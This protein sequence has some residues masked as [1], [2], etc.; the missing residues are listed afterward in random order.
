MIAI[1]FQMLKPVD[2]QKLFIFVVL[3]PIRL[4][5][6]FM[7]DHFGPCWLIAIQVYCCLPPPLAIALQDP[8][9]L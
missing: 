7:F 8:V 1:K 3:Q 5:G 9:G 4:L 6:G 2:P